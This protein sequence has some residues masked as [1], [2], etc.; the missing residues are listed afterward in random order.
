[1][2]LP[3]IAILTLASGMSIAMACSN[4]TRHSPPSDN[5]LVVIHSSGGPA[6]FEQELYVYGDGRVVVELPDGVTY[7][8]SNLTPPESRRLR[9]ALAEQNLDESD[10]GRGCCDDFEEVVVRYRGQVL[11]FPC[12]EGVMAEGFRDLGSILNGITRDHFGIQNFIP[13]HCLDGDSAL[14]PS[15]GRRVLAVGVSPV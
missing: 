7:W 4:L 15:R 11:S 2:Y 6:P 3:E 10:Y 14:S 8:K 1:M 13:T 5:T 12:M 9:E